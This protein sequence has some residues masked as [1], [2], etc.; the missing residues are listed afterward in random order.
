MIGLSKR[1]IEVTARIGIHVPT[2]QASRNVVTAVQRL[3]S[4]DTLILIGYADRSGS[5]AIRRLAADLEASGYTIG[6]IWR[7]AADRYHCLACP[8]CTAPE[9][10]PLKADSVAAA[11][12]TY[13]GVA[14]LADREAIE[15]LVAPRSG[16]TVATGRAKRSVL[17]NPSDPGFVDTALAMAKKGRRLNDDH[18]AELCLRLHDIACHDHAWLRTD[19]EQWQ[20]DLWLDMTRRCPP[21]LVAP[22]ATLLAWCA[23]RRGSGAVAAASVNRALTADPNYS[24]AK[25]IATLLRECVPPSAIPVWPPPDLADDPFNLP[26][27]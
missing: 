25:L 24:L 12:F 1:R 5:D 2:D 26:S 8:E 10:K 23:W 7:V 19:A 21:G 6:Q 18:A 14:P 11:T 16:H 4:V 27:R 9:G 17:R 3:P 22:A 13:H 20:F 15:K